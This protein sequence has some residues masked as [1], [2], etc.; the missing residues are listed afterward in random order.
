MHHNSQLTNDTTALL[1]RVFYIQKNIIETENDA[2]KFL[3]N[4]L[5]NIIALGVNRLFSS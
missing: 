1:S 2:F 5:F 4:F 3:N